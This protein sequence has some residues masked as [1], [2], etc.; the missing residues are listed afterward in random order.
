MIR[1]QTQLSSVLAL[2][3]GEK[4]I[5][6]AHAGIPAL[7]PRPLS[8]LTNSD[9]IVHDILALIQEQRAV[10]LVMGLPRGL[11]GQETAQTRIVEEF[12]HTL[13]EHLSIP[14]YWQDEAVTSRQ[15]EEELKARGKPYE[16]GDID[17]LAATYILEDFLHEHKEK[18]A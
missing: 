8:T 18:F 12:G 9:Q 17:A 15:A 4:R 5:G 1:N 14:L 16:K 7:L 6:V 13:E 3:V 11:Q 10:A 2:D